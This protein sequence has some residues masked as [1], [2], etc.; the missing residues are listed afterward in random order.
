[1]GKVQEPLQVVNNFPSPATDRHPS[2]DGKST[3]RCDRAQGFPTV[4]VPHPLEKTRHFGLRRGPVSPARRPRNAD[5]L[6]AEPKRENTFGRTRH[7]PSGRPQTQP[8]K[9]VVTLP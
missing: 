4:G 6:R 5:A 8:S 2:G 7:G 3:T 1:M 9:G